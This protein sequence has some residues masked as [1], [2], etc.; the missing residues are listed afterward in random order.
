[1]VYRSNIGITNHLATLCEF[2]IK[3]QQ[4]APNSPKHNH[5]LATGITTG[6]QISGKEGKI[7]KQNYP[8]SKRVILT[9]LSQTRT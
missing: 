7:T 3:T 1:M 5:W 4:M 2:C 6:H 9:A 8:T